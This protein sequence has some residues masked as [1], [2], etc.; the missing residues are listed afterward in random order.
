[1]ILGV[2][3]DTLIGP[4]LLGGV[5]IGGGTLSAHEIFLLKKTCIPETTS[6]KDMLCVNLCVRLFW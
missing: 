1:M 4:C 3:N 2:V 5:G 6:D